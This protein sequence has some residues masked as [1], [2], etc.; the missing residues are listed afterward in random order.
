M[1][2]ALVQDVAA[3]WEQYER[4]A[5]ALVEPAPAGLLLH[6]A[7]PTE[8][9]FR[10]IDVWESEEAW[11]H[12]QT[13]LLNPAIAALGGP[14]RPEPTFRDIHPA[15]VVVGALDAGPRRGHRNT[16]KGAE[17]RRLITVLIG[18]AAIAAI[19]AISASSASARPRGT[20][21]KISI[22]RADNSAT[23]EE[24]T[25]TVEPD[26][27]DLSMLANNSEGGGWSSDGSRV[28]IG[29]QGLGAG[30][31]EFDTGVFTSLNLESQY[32][33]IFLGC[34]IW[35]P[36]DSRL[37][38]EGL[39]DG[40]PSLNGIY[41]VRSSDGGDLR[42]VTFN[43][44]G[45][46]CPSD[47]SPSGDR[48]VFTHLTDTSYG[49][50]TV[51][52]NGTGL[53]RISPEGLNFNSCNGSWSPQGNEILLAAHQPDFDYHSSMWVLHANGTGLRRI[54]AL[55]CGGRNDDPNGVGCF[56]PSWS[57]DGQKIVFGRR[58]DDQPRDIYT[59]NVDGS[60]LFRVTDT[61]DI[62]EYSADWGA[63]PLTP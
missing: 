26:G 46:D 13:E 22:T 52:P 7:G 49:L 48:I 23:G 18:L 31:L 63:H 16:T 20:N 50:H 3:S 60:G 28:A 58:V 12:F 45:D 33:G 8:E 61:P 32:P 9:G 62:E 19:A 43:P 4:V 25:F 35:S 30:I 21:G 29:E 24:Q 44:G 59:V 53:R 14:S 1:I 11:Q 41:T 5:A 10:T 39:S 55:D 38:C 27:S 37:A 40:D 15:H 36:D 2:Y 56:N 57:P 34:E 42:R 6:V 51:S 54:P 47:Y 17:M